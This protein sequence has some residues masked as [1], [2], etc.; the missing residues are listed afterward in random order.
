MMIHYIC[1]SSH[2]ESSCI[3]VSDRAQ[4]IY[5]KSKKKKKVNSQLLHFAVGIK[6]VLK[7]MKRV[8]TLTFHYNLES[9][10][11]RPEA[12]MPPKNS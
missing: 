7:M 12:Y 10:E 3:P 8:L 1:R 5:I 4:N 6:L 9:K 11:K 2:S